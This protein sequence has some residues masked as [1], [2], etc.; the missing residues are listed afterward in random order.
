MYAANTRG[1]GSAHHDHKYAAQPRSTNTKPRYIGFRVTRYT[2]ESTIADVAWGFI[3]LMVVFARRNA[4]RPDTSKAA[5]TTANKIARG[6]RTIAGAASAPECPGMLHIASAASSATSGGG[7]LSSRAR[8][9]IMTRRR[10]AKPRRRSRECQR[11]A[12]EP[13]AN[14]GG[15]PR[16][17]IRAQCPAALL[18]P[19]CRLLPAWQ[20]VR[21]TPA[22]RDS[23]IRGG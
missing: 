12:G 13:R 18:N 23:T 21:A 15:C 10:D 4:M 19:E 16:S 8:M 14:C 1:P 17:F 9:T 2:P 7:I 22:I 6:T 11:A 20:A 5:P 3:G